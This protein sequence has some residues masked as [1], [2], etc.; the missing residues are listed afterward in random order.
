MKRLFVIITLILTAAAFYTWLIQPEQ[1]EEVPVM[2]WKSD[3]NPQR[4]EQIRLFHKWLIDKGHVNEKG[5]PEVELRLDPSSPQTS[6]IHAVSGVGGDVIDVYEVT[7]F[8]H[9]MG[10]A[11]DLTPYVAK[12]HYDIS[13]TYPGL[14]GLF[15]FDGHQYAYLCNGSVYNM[16]F[17]VDTLKKYGMSPP[18]EEWTPEE[19]EKYAA[20]YVKRANA[21]N[22]NPR[23]FFGQ[24]IT[25]QDGFL[26]CI[27]RSEG[28]DFYNETLTS[29]TVNN[30]ATLKG[31]KLFYKWTYKDRLFPTS[32]D[33]ASANDAGGYGGM[34]YSQFI[35]GK[36]AMIIAGR[37]ALIRFRELSEPLTVCSSQ[38]P[39]YGFKNMIVSARSV[40][41][42]KGSKNKDL[43]RL[44]FEF[45]AD[46]EYNEY[47]IEGSDGLPPN[48]SYAVGNPKYLN[49][50]PNEGNVHSAELKWALK[51]SYSNAISPYFNLLGTNWT[52]QAMGKYFSEQASAEEALAEAQMRYNM[53]IAD[54]IRDNSE[55]RVRWEKGVADQKI[56][57]ECKRVGKKI[58]AKLIANPFYLGYYR[59]RGMLEE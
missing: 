46:R 30:P 33:V 59:S 40:I 29:S 24:S 38:Y 16:W 27:T 26:L 53:G 19:F 31:L 8:F 37:F 17:N 54:T 23:L 5:R 25:G 57:D 50:R 56:I 52:T 7:R 13:H 3:A 14:D 43:A 9:S 34:N 22:P 41:M 12:G 6:M 28:Y 20:E 18:P 58:P 32:A 21:D 55:L 39:M 47:I 44:F 1:Q 45:L 2:Y 42:Y 35:N 51:C 36:L 10:V 49:P 15:V 48:P 4:Y 11:E